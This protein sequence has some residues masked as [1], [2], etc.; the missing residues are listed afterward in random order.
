ME[1]MGEICHHLTT[2]KYNQVGEV[3]VI[4]DKYYNTR[5]RAIIAELRLLDHADVPFSHC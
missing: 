3:W 1:G 5:N 2:A 4:L